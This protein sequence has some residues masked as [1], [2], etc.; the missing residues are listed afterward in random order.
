MNK[1]LTVFEALEQMK[2]G[3][4]IKH[5]SW[6]KGFWYLNNGEVCTEDGTVIKKSTFM[7]YVLQDD[8]EW[9]IYEEV[10]EIGEWLTD[11]KIVIKYAH[12]SPEGETPIKYYEEE[13]SL[14][15]TS[16][17]RATKEEIEREL[18]SR[19]WVHWGRK[20]EEWRIGDI[21]YDQSSNKYL[22]KG[23]LMEITAEVLK[24]KQFEN[25]KMVCPT[26]SRVDRIHF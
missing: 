8:G 10:Y 23:Q 11:G 13:K 12:L 16:V 26:E 15:K 17:R 3:K 5:K 1:K 14:E 4:K 2:S 24:N 7:S 6:K 18:E 19:K 9:E 20:V 22:S 21:V 25:F